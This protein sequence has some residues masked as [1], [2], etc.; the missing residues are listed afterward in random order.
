M[1][2]VCSDAEMVRLI[3]GAKSLDGRSVDR[4]YELYADKVFRYIWYRVGERQTAED[5]TMDVFI[6]FLEHIPRFRQQPCNRSLSPKS[7]TARSGDG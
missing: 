1:N 5:F 2:D 7:E 4:L 3:E 6:R